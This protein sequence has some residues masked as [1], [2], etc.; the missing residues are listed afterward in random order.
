MYSFST[1]S[2]YL[3]CFFSSSLFNLY[4]FCRFQLL[5]DS[6]HFFVLP[7]V[8]FVFSG[9][10]LLGFKVCELKILDKMLT[11]VSWFQLLLDNTHF[12]VNLPKVDFVFS[13]PIY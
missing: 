4:R 10:H 5:L 1:L 6:A 3:E 9:P 12:F 13:G 7:K 8:D 2:V 11:K